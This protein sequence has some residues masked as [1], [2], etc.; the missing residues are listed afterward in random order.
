MK[1][2]LLICCA[3]S[4]G[5]GL[6]GCARITSQV[7]EKPR[8]DQEIASGNR[9][10]LNGSAPLASERKTTRQVVQTDIE[11]PTVQELTPWKIHKGS[12]KAQAP[13]SSAWMPPA[14][15]LPSQESQ[16]QPVQEGRVS[17][18]PVIH[19]ERAPFSVY[20][21][22]KGD[23]LEKIASKVYGDSNQWR[24]IY[25]ANRE[26]LSSPNRVYPGQKLVIP[27]ASTQTRRQPRSSEDLK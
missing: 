1:R 5:L 16:W 7:V 2:W 26:K 9:G 21:V 23:S 8:V 3:G 18:Q 25:K 6:V 11:L 17:S 19:Q 24:R 15:P 22:Q 4:F 10:Y 12:A 14:E 13:K 20:T 27:P